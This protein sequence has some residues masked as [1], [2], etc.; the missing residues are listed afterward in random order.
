[1]RRAIPFAAVAAALLAA[2]ISFSRAQDAQRGGANAARAW[3]YRVVVL[4]DVVGVQQALQQAPGKT[5]AALESKFNELG[6]DGWEY[7]GDL[8]GAAVFKRPK[9]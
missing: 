5:G 9:R 7:C 4:T 6:Q 1:M 3:E 8:P 2:W